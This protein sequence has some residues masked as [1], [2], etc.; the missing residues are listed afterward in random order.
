MTDSSRR[1]DYSTHANLPAGSTSENGG[2]LTRTQWPWHEQPLRHRSLYKLKCGNGPSTGPPFP[3]YQTASNNACESFTLVTLSLS[4]SLSR[5]I[6]IFMQSYFS[7]AN[8]WVSRSKPLKNHVPFDA[9][10]WSLNVQTRSPGQSFGSTLQTTQ[11]RIQCLIK[12]LHSGPW[13]KK[14]TNILW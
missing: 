2:L 9:G 7:P 11:C 8:H 4:L 3:H 10:P 14:F 6:Y 13:C 1:S 5:Y 12:V